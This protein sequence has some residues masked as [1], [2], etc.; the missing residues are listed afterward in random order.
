MLKV[1]IKLIPALKAKTIEIQSIST[2]MI[3]KTDKIWKHKALEDFSKS[4]GCNLLPE[5]HQIR[6]VSTVL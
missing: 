6:K 1:N 3:M 4:S 2:L 5:V